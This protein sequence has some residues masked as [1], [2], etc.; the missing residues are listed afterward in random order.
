MNKY[1]EDGIKTYMNALHPIVYIK[2]F[3]T[4]IID[5]AL[6]NLGCKE[7]NLKITNSKSQIESDVVDIIE[8]AK[9]F[10]II[11]N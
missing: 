11:P 1:I 8:R 10:F 2:H 7:N 4:N 6:S 3:D 9:I 5:E